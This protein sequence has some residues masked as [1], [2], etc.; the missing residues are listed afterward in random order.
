MTATAMGLSPRSRRKTCVGG[1]MCFS[2]GGGGGLRGLNVGERDSKSLT[3]LEKKKKDP[4][5]LMSQF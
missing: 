1:S 2:G 3:S 5:M 4:Q